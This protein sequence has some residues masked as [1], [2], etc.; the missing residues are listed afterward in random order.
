M[1]AVKVHVLF[2]RSYHF[3]IIHKEQRQCFK[4]I[5]VSALTS[6]FVHRQPT[7]YQKY[8]IRTKI[9][10][11]TPLQYASLPFEK[12]SMGDL[13][14][15]TRQRIAVVCLL[16]GDFLRTLWNRESPSVIK[17][18]LQQ[19]FHHV[20]GAFT[21]WTSFGRW[22]VQPFHE[23]RKFFSTPSC[24]SPHFI[25]LNDQYVRHMAHTLSSKLSCNVE[26]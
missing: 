7:I 12:K 16:R 13:I 14:S 6:H 21:L 19:K 24:G 18:F 9:T 1:R 11:L 3:D 15:F 26:A 4:S 22:I 20:R 5:W 25:N 17:G 2:P 10:I 23:K 8:A